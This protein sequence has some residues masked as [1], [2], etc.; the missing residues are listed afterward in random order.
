MQGYTLA[1]ASK[2]DSLIAAEARYKSPQMNAANHVSFSS[3]LTPILCS[4]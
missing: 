4:C 3:L 2:K 1:A